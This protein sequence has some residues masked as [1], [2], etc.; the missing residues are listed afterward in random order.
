M[1]VG[2]RFP[3][4][5][6]F[7]QEFIQPNSYMVREVY[8]QFERLPTNKRILALWDF[9]CSE[10]AY[11]ISDSGEY[12]DYHEINAFLKADRPFFGHSYMVKGQTEEFFQFPSETLAFAVGDCDCLAILLTSLLR[13][14]LPPPRVYAVIGEFEG[15]GHA[16][17]EA[18]GRILEAT[19]Q[20]ATD[21]TP[22][23][24]K[25]YSPIYRF[26]DMEV[27]MAAKEEKKELNHSQE[28]K[29]LMKIGTL[30]KKKAKGT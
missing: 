15:Y 10:I 6:H 11:P 4:E 23:T 16:W 7:L 1:I 18:E 25:Y 19:L 5:K 20:A 12:S 21:F 2:Y 30:W 9:V 17:V 26:N 24:D 3:G 29:K 8:K 27:L 28:I 22:D 13:N 14:M